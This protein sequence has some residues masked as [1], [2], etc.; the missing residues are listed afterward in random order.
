M[1]ESIVS[2]TRIAAE[3][4]E[5][6]DSHGTLEAHKAA[7]FIV[8]KNNPL[9]DITEVSRLRSVYQDGLLQK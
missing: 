6:L 4:L 5:V 8:M 7:D 2:A 9:K 3:L 1:M